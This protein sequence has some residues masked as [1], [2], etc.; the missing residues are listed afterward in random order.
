[1]M[2]IL[3]I[4]NKYQIRGGEYSVLKNEARLLNKEGNSIEQLF[5][6][7]E[8]IQSLKDKLITGF[9][10]L[11]NFKSARLLKRKIIKFKPDIIHVHNYFPLAS[12]SIF[13]VANKKKI[14]IVM[15]LHNYRLICPNALLLKNN[16][17]CELCVNKSFAFDGVLNSCY[18]D[19]RA[20]TFIL[21]FMSF[22]HKKFK[23][24][25]TKID[26]YIALT[27]FAKNKMENS[28]L[29]L[30]NDKIVVK[31]NF[32]EDYGFEN[33]KEDYFLFIG[34]LS[35]EKGIDL[36]LNAFI[37]NGEPLQIIGKG[38]KEKNVIDTASKYANISY[39]GF[40]EK[41]FIMQKLRK[42]RALIFTSICYETFG[43]TII[44]AFSTGTPVIGPNIGGP[45]EIINHG[46]NGLIYQVS[47]LDDL[48][49]KIYLLNT[50]ESLQSKLSIGARSS[51]ELNYSPEKNYKM[52]M[53]IYK[54][55]I[56]EKT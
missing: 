50:E 34:R 24:W 7:N 38:P 29:K 44:E 23:T 55:V 9:N 46:E 36:L 18:R 43:M 27:N 56:H 39:L 51:Y 13:Y 52:L 21:A 30:K 1:M 10:V 12:P 45:N 5:F 32:V 40:Q 37:L 49:R 16:Q 26:K 3:Q 8:N 53:D 47:D 6:E 11:Y 15:T 48:N 28:S 25:N 42:A 35:E 4:H 19:S 14:P 22:M 20:Q 31:P 2:R 54:E 33:T 17:I 41:A